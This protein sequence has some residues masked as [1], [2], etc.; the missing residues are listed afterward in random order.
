[1]TTSSKGQHGGYREG[2]GR[3][4]T[5]GDLQR[6]NLRMDADLVALALVAGDGE[7]SK[8]VRWLLRQ[9]HRVHR[10]DATRELPPNNCNVLVFCRDG[11]HVARLDETGKWRLSYGHND[12]PELDGVVV[13]CNLPP[14]PEEEPLIVFS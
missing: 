2:A 12:P 7:F 13:W 11:W 14:T 8:G 6:V 4:P 3:K 1:M 10:H 9:A 5:P